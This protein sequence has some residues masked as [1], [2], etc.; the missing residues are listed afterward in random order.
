[1]A[2]SNNN[3]IADIEYIHQLVYD[4]KLNEL[5]QIL[6]AVKHNKSGSKQSLRK[7]VLNLLSAPTPKTKVLKQKIIQV[8][9]SRP[10]QIQQLQQP[11]QAPVVQ[12]PNFL[13]RFLRQPR[14][15]IQNHSQSYTPPRPNPIQP[16]VET[17][18]P[19][20]QFDHLPFFK[21]VQTLLMPMY[22][23]TNI[24]SAN[25]TGLFYLT[26]N[27]RHSIVKSWNIAR[28]EYKIQIILRLLQVG[29]DE[30]VT[31]RLPY[32]I[33]VSVNDRQCKLPTLNIPTKAGITPW[34]CNVPI[35]ITQQTDLRNCLQNTL[36]ITWSE[37]PHEYMAGVYVANKLTWNDL[38]VELKKRPLRASD[39]TKELIKKSMENDADMGVDSM[40]ATVKDPLTKLRMKLPARGVDCIH[41]QCF[42]AIQFL[43]MN[44]QKQT[45]TCPLCKKKLKFENIEVDEFFLN[46]LQSPDLSEE[47]ENV[48]L[49]KDGTWSERKNK[50]FSNNSRTNDY[51]STN[52][53]EVFTLSDSDDDNDADNRNSDVDNVDNDVII[54]KPKRFKYNPSKVE[55]SVIKS[56]HVIETEDLT[57][58][59]ESDLVLDLSI[60]NNSMSSVSGSSKYEP[61]VTLN[62]DSNPSTSADSRY[63]PIITLNDDSDQSTSTI[64]KYE[65]VIVLSDEPDL[66]PLIPLMESTSMLNNLYLPNISITGPN[67]CVAGSSRSS[68]NNRNNRHQEKDNS[69]SVLCVITLD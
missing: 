47:C 66:P 37:E 25:F 60:K 46:M 61:I 15:N 64:S 28:Q 49:L 51:G 5:Q 1:M 23:Q 18:S 56:E 20:I 31:E 32:N 57:D 10:Q 69:R 26:D 65:P 30:N 48:V 16:F 29:I 19:A 68:R 36:K 7:R 21:T 67:N 58:P 45:W 39:K 53:I 13:Q 34:R 22:C 6:E 54:S 33:T 44:E 35:D 14:N 43:Q 8:Y 63:G 17:P 50:E 11:P 42:D 27:V 52:N 12:Q 40:F 59:S 2:K 9:N 4:L 55:E 24:D 38:L 62:D 41:L 3:L